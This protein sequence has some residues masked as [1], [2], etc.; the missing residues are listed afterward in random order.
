MRATDE[1]SFLE[2]ACRIIVEDCGYKMVWLGLKEDDKA[3]TI[4]PVSYAGFDKGYLDSLKVTWADNERG[5]GPTG[6]AVRTGKP[7]FCENMQTDLTLKPWRE[8]A[9]K[10]GY[11][12]SVALPLKSGKKVF[13]VLTLYSDKPNAC[14]ED[15]IKLLTELAGD[16]SHGIM[17]LRLRAEKERA[18]EQIHRQAQLIDLSPDAI[19][20]RNFNGKITSWSKGAEKL[21]GWTK[22]E[23]IGKTTHDLFKTKFPKHFED[24][25]KE[26]NAKKRWTGELVHTTKSGKE[27]TVQSW[28]LAERTESGE[29]KSI[30]ESN[31][32]LTERKKAER[33]IARLASFPTLNPSP[34]IE[35]DFDGRLTYVNPATS[36]QFPDLESEGLSHP[37]FSDWKNAVETFSRKNTNTFSRELKIAGHWYHQQFYLVPQSQSIRVYATDIDELKLTEEARAR[38]QEKLEENAVLLEEYANQMENLAEQRAQQ[39]K[40]AERMAAIGQTASMVGHDIRNPLQAITSDMYLI[41]EEVKTMQDGDSKQA[42][43]ES[44][45]SVTEN[46]GYINKI[47]SDLQDSTRP[48]K[49]N[50]QQANLSELIQG[51]LL[52]ISTPKTIK[53]ATDIAEEAKPIETDVA[54]LRRLLTNLFT[55][56]VQAM[57]DTQSGKLTITA[58]VKDSKTVISV[59]DT[60]V[61]IPKEVK[62]KMFTPLFTTKS[63]GQGLGLAVVKRLVEALGGTIQFES[64]PNKGTKFTVELPQNKQ[65]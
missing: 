24:I 36:S 5:R 58:S 63:K 19:I 56:G 17:M 9:L 14:S 31:V 54:Y 45:D 7:Q 61:G 65:P 18:E 40:D 25:I 62:E 34:V 6:R 3:K 4:R 37:F 38:T 28:W 50:I 64:E 48:L 10:R 39:L 33:E 51:I 29:I 30:L 2:E 13:G 35:A 11:A 46:I 57:Q 8:E 16:F 53:V 15:E 42:I 60:G 1:A 23:A 59:G 21:Y 43:L 20:V 12:S 22:E 27:V 26:L 55:N 44:V 41:M 32:D 52:T 49:P 47:V